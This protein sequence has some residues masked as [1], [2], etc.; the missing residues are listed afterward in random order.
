MILALLFLVVDQSIKF[1]SSYYFPTQLFL[2]KQLAFGIGSPW[3]ILLGLAVIV[4]FGYKEKFQ[5]RLAWWL[6][7]A[8][9]LSNLIDRLRI[10]AVADY[11]ATGNLHLNL[12]DI[13]ICSTVAYIAFY[14][15][16]KDAP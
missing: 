2:N 13:L 15:I 3:L 4:A 8:G 10:G 12:A 11:I 1:F 5:P 7:S 14:Y 6:L 16:K 9:V